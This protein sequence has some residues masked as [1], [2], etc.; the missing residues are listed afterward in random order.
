LKCHSFGLFFKLT[1]GLPTL[2]S[3]LQIGKHNFITGIKIE[4]SRKIGINI[5]N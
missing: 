2:I 4:S 5:Q 1:F 3:K